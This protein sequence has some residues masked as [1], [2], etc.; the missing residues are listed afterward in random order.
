LG[1]ASRLPLR[2]GINGGSTTLN[3]RA[4]RPAMISKGSRSVWESFGSPTS[5]ALATGLTERMQAERM[6]VV[7]VDRS[8]GQFLCAEHRRWTQ[9]ANADVTKLAPGDIVRVERGDDQVWKIRVVRTA[10][11]ELASPEM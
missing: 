8:R 11:E 6:T 1:A 5:A 2:S 7:Q 4:R 9:V 10:S 3:T